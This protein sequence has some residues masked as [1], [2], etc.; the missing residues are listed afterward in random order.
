MVVVKAGTSTRYSKAVSF[1]DVVSKL[2][3]WLI[4]LTV[5]IVLQ[6]MC[7]NNYIW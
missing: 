3:L 5:H 4:N 7:K 2:K 6:A 1:K